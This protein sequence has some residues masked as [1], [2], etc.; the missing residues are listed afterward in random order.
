MTTLDAFVRRHP[1]PIYFAV[2]FAIS[3]GGVLAVLGPGGV[4]EDKD[5]YATVLPFA[6]GAMLAGPSVA[7]LLLT[8]LLEG[9]AGFHVLLS[10]LLR[11]RVGARW[12]AVALLLAPLVI[13]AM[14][15]ALSL[16]SPV[17]IPGLIATDDKAGR[18]AFG[19]TA[20]V[21]TGILEELGWTGFATPRLRARYSILA[22]GLLIGVPW[23][24]WH[25]IGTV[26]MASG[27]Y[28][29]DLS[30]P[31]FV[32]GRTLG[33]LAGGLPAYRVLMV[34][35]YD[36]TGSLLVAMVMHAS[37]TAATLTLEPLMITGVDL[38]LHDLVS[39][40][41]WWAVV[42]VVAVATGGALTRP[43]TQ[44]RAT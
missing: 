21:V 24:A 14:L 42:A 1:V 41:T 28:A 30:L 31:T 23:G 40:I 19:L 44:A 26:G 5:R 32:A 15:F 8:S 37:L 17:F 43:A 11:W 20:A 38:L 9:R 13:L 3:W 29:G 36:R 4:P 18:L 22:T 39:T 7:G 33:L 35:V 25:I 6:I 2:T 27:I 34:W 10:R 12:Y 16:I